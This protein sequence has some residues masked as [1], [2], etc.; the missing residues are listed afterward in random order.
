VH[1][2]QHVLHEIL[3]FGATCE[4]PLAAHELP[5]A[6]RD[7]AKQLEVRAGVALLRSAHQ[8]TERI[9]W[10]VGCCHESSAQSTPRVTFFGRAPNLLSLVE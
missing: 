5:D 4:A 2:Q 9:D 7:G 6:R 10:R 1:R 3:D 8:A